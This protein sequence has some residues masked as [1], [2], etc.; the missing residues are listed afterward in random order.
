MFICVL[1]FALF[2][3]AVGINLYEAIK[4]KQFT[5]KQKMQ[6]RAVR[7][8]TRAV[9]VIV[10]LIALFDE[11]NYKMWIFIFSLAAVGTGFLVLDVL[12][13]ELE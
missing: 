6:W 7:M 1:A 12:G 10:A 4:R 8:A 3:Q 9:A 11:V 13:I 5:A 2:M